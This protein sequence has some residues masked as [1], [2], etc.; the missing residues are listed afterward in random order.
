MF[1]SFLSLARFFTHGFFQ[2]SRWGAGFSFS[3]GH[4]VVNVPYD[5]YLPLIFQVR[6]MPHSQTTNQTFM[7]NRIV[8]ILD[9]S[10][11]IGRRDECFGKG[12]FLWV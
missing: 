8:L 1:R 4:F 10:S 12:L 9:F 11:I 7:Y 2:N 3:R 5:Q 6:T